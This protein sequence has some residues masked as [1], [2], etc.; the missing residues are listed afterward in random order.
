MPELSSPFSNGPGQPG[1]TLE[2]LLDLETVADFLGKG[3]HPSGVQVRPS[4]DRTATMGGVLGVLKWQGMG[5]LPDS[6][7]V[8]VKK[9]LSSDEGQVDVWLHAVDLM[10]SEW[11]EA[12]LQIEL[13]YRQSLQFWDDIALNAPVAL[14]LL[15]VVAVCAAL[16]KAAN[17]PILSNSGEVLEEA[18]D[19]FK[20]L[21][22]DPQYAIGSLRHTLDRDRFLRVVTPFLTLPSDDPSILMMREEVGWAGAA[23]SV[24][25]QMESE[26]SFARTFLIA[27]EVESPPKYNSVSSLALFLGNADMRTKRRV[28]RLPS[29]LRVGLLNECESL[30]DLRRL[31]HVDEGD[32]GNI[33]GGVLE[34][35]LLAL[36]R[37]DVNWESKVKDLT[38]L[39]QIVFLQLP[40]P[41]LFQCL[42]V[43][44]GAKGAV[45]VLPMSI[46]LSDISTSLLLSAFPLKNPDLVKIEGRLKLFAHLQIHSLPPK[47]LPV[48]GPVRTLLNSYEAP[49]LYFPSTSSLPPFPLPSDWQPPNEE[50]IEIQKEVE[51]RLPTEEEKTE[52]AK[53]DGLFER[54]KEALNRQRGHGEKESREEPNKKEPSTETESR[55][56]ESDTAAVTVGAEA[57]VSVSVDGRSPAGGR[58]QKT[59]RADTQTETGGSVSLDSA[60]LN[61]L[62]QLMNMGGMGQRPHSHG[63]GTERGHSG[64]GFK[65][66]SG[67]GVSHTSVLRAIERGSEE[68]AVVVALS[69]DGGGSGTGLMSAEPAGEAESV[70]PSVEHSVSASASSS[71]PAGPSETSKKME[72]VSSGGDGGGWRL[73]GSETG[74]ETGA[75]SGGAEEGAGTW[76]PSPSG[77]RGGSAESGWTSTGGGGSASSSE[78]SG[79]WTLVK[80]G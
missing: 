58:A 50:P 31:L 64:V 18:T 10:A 2:P 38:P 55:T 34:H 39:A 22:L 6:S 4:F 48:P 14:T 59:L 72:G 43:E 60:S 32:G 46:F 37:G 9:L 36:D 25:W 41:I 17:D 66:A 26:G 54:F 49:P 52:E 70:P 35:D 71:A 53:G 44:D 30:E 63:M 21:P 20:A 16:R 69:A 74:Q 62:H 51:I 12:W 56:E 29:A 27:R 11:E 15:K 65:V 79:G 8:T 28:L 45:S 75:N 61:A 5:V 73:V 13:W 68:D 77:E 19:V 23:K 47:L 57:D 3:G 78:D 67:S 42:S 1:V 76:S 7:H 33:L 24:G 40:L 80:S